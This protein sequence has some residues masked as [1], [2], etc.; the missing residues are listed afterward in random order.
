MVLVYLCGWLVTTVGVAITATHF[1]DREMS[2]PLSVGSLA[3]LAGAL[4][5]VM[6][7]G[8]MELLA[9]AAV[10]KGMRTRR[11]LRSENAPTER[12]EELIC[13]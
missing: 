13:T 10:A 7:I 11:T 5:P 1:S 12:E 8:V 6:V 4:W 3:V 2:R 9:I